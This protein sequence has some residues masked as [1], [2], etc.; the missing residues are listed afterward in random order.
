MNT[1]FFAAFSPL[2]TA[3]ERADLED[4]QK[5]FLRSLGSQNVARQCAY[6]NAL[7]A[8]RQWLLGGVRTVA[9]AYSSGI[10]RWVDYHRLFDVPAAYPHL[11]RYM[12]ALALDPAV[13]FAQSLEDDRASVSSGRFL[14]HV[15]LEELNPN[16]DVALRSQIHNAAPALLR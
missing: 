4:E 12:R 5:T 1:D 9:D 3:Y 2:W 13:Q 15:T 8:D 11:H 14:G 16:P 10:C 7:L 6:L